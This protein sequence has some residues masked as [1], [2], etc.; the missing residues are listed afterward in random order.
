MLTTT[1]G[2]MNYALFHFLCFFGFRRNH[3]FF[4]KKKPLRSRHLISK[5]LGIVCFLIPATFFLFM[6][7]PAAAGY[8]EINAL[9]ANYNANYCNYGPAGDLSGP[10]T[11]ITHGTYGCAHDDNMLQSLGY[12][13]FRLWRQGR[14]FN[15]R[16]NNVPTDEQIIAATIVWPFSQYPGGGDHPSTSTREL[17]NRGDIFNGVPL[18]NTSDQQY[19]TINN[20]GLSYIQSHVASSALEFVMRD[21]LD[22]LDQSPTYPGNSGGNGTQE[23]LGDPILQIFTAQYQGDAI[24][25]PPVC[26]SGEDCLAPV[27]VATGTTFSIKFGVDVGP[28]S[29]L[30]G[31]LTEVS[32]AYFSQSPSA[33]DLGNVTP[34]DHTL[35]VITP[36]Q[37][38]I[39]NFST[40]AASSTRCASYTPTGTAAYD[41]F[42]AF[43]CEGLATSTNP[44]D[45]DN[46]LCGLRKFGCW[47][48]RPTPQS[49]SYVGTQFSSIT[50]RFPLAPFTKAYQDLNL[51]NASSSDQTIAPGT[52]DIP[53]WSSSTKTYIGTNYNLGSSTLTQSYGWKKFRRLE[54]IGMWCIGITPILLILI[55]LII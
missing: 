35:C 4:L 37:A 15:L 50:A 18:S 13:Q 51:I 24:I 52:I 31:G 22:Y 1:Y 2:K 9:P 14:K 7:K 3:L 29:V 30:T 53:F 26:C 39:I 49:V 43:P 20:A 28:C 40:L 33:L 16:D 17:F 36:S 55:K 6:A 5:V 44:L 47:F 48:V 21:Y 11:N 41:S 38:T 42:C 10:W 12:G 23:V 45:L 46:F 8:Y 19:F 32:A 34:G 54:V 27:T 25:T